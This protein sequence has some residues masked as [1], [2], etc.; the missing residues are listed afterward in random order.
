MKLD[1][2]VGISANSKVWKNRKF[3]WENLAK[4]L[5]TPVKV[6]KTRKEFMSATKQ[7]QTAIK[8]VG[9]YVGGYLREGKRSPQNVTHRQLLTLDVD[10]GQGD[11]WEDF[12]LLFDCAALLHGTFKHSAENSTYRYRLV[13]PTSRP[14]TPDEYQAVARRV[15]GDLVID[16]FDTTTFETNRL[17]FWP[18]CPSDVEFYVREQQGEFLD[19]DEQLDRYVDWTDCSQWPNAKQVDTEIRTNIKKQEDPLAKKGIVGAFCRTYTIAEA[20]AKFL[21]DVYIEAG[22]RFTYVLGSTAAGLTVYDDVFAYSHHGS[23]P[24]S[25]KLVNAFDLVRIHLYGLKDAGADSTTSFKLMETLARED[26]EVRKLVAKEKIATSQYDFKEI[27]ASDFDEED[28]FTPDVEE[29]VDWMKDLEIDTKGRYLSTAT[30]L[31]I[32]FKND[33]VLKKAFQYN[34]FSAKRFVRSFPWRKVEGELDEMQDVDYSG[35]RN[36]LECIYGVVSVYKIEDSLNLEF[37]KNSFHPIQEYLRALK[38]DGVKRVDTLLTDYFNT[39]LNVYTSEA[40]RKMLVG[41]IS[42]VFHAGCKFDLVMTFVG[43]Q[44]T[45]KSTFIRLLGGQWSSDTFTTVHGQQSFE[46]IQ[47]KWVVEIAELSAL[48]KSDVESVKHYITK[49]DDTYRPPW[50]RV[51]QTFKRQCIFFATTNEDDPFSDA[52]GNRR[53]LP[54]RVERGRKNIWEDFEAE[55]DQI[56]AE[57]MQLYRDG[58]SLFLSDEAEAIA[59]KEQKAHSKV[60]DRQGILEEYL[61]MRVPTNW[62]EMDVYERRQYFSDYKEDLSNSKLVKRD[63]VCTAQ[64][65]CECF[66][67]EKEDMSRYTTRDINDMMKGVS[68]WNL[69]TSNKRFTTYGKQRFFIRR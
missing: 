57:A 3:T 23:D 33:K 19:V 16:L 2:A 12:M 4:K 34:A 14:M 20:I 43:G 35:I 64:I 53:F 18:A 9:G 56:W 68:D 1:I 32:I 61:D 69:S 54:I 27:T 65:W 60:D 66:G 8:D 63:Y 5:S 6:D 25:Q 59:K 15:A 52:T 51:P 58:E 22:E 49:Q 46:Q 10:F 31:N 41:A 13:I 21:S 37:A 47:G 26:T 17:M 44:G 11:F 45:G 28:E 55:R 7:D 29:S 42:R 50:G 40:M 30:N 39:P 36:Y 62:E 24:C 38:W 48:K 67:K